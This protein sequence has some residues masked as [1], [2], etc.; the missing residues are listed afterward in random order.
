MSGSIR[1]RTIPTSACNGLRTEAWTRPRTLSRLAIPC[2]RPWAIRCCTIRARRPGRSICAASRWTPWC[3]RM[4]TPVPARRSRARIC[5]SRERAMPS[6]TAPP[7]RRSTPMRCCPDCCWPRRRSAPMRRRRQRRP[8]RWTNS[9]PRCMGSAPEWRRPR[10]N[11]ARPIA[12]PWSRRIPAMRAPCWITSRCASRGSET[13]RR[14]G[15]RRRRRM[16]GGGKS[17]CRFAT[18]WSPCSSSIPGIIIPVI[19]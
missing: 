19:R 12:N 5:G 2:A 7:I 1:E 8:R 10:Q 16:T 14:S 18:W 6:C 11:S 3:M 4:R 15:R 9:F 17:C 13:C